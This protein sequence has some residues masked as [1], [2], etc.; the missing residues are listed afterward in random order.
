MK[1]Y[2]NLDRVLLE[3]TLDNGGI[4]RDR[5]VSQQRDEARAF[6]EKHG[7]EELQ[8]YEDWLTGFSRNDLQIIAVGGQDEPETI[9]LRKGAPDGFNDFLNKY[10]DEVC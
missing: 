7:E 8:L 10:F 5:P 4:N 9:K 1:I 2:E 3:I 6:L